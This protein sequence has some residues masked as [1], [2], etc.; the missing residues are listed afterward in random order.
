MIIASLQ[1]E[2]DKV[3]TW[4]SNAR[5]TLNASKSKTAFFSLDMQKW[6]GNLT[7]LLTGNAYLASP[8]GFLSVQV[9][10]HLTFGEHVRE[11]CQS[12]SHCINLLLGGKIW[13]WHTSD[14]HLVY[15]AAVRSMLNTQL[16]S[17]HL[18]CHLPP[19]AA[20]LRVQLE[21]IG[22]ITDLVRSTPVEAVLAE[23]QRHHI[24]RLSKP[25]PS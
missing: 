22:A 4:S 14:R 7:S 9:Q 3:F 13:G 1:P 10:R 16:L 24:Q 8:P 2:V 15:I 23:A 6:P 19:P 17:G 18:S 25:F 11:L 5:L 21:A 12:M 20:N